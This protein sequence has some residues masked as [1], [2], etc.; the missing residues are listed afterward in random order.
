MSPSSE[1]SQLPERMSDTIRQNVSAYIRKTFLFSDDA[2]L[3][4][5]QSLLASG[6]IDS[7]GVLELINYLESTYGIRFGDEELVADN[8][9]SVARVS[10]FL[11]TKL[12]QANEASPEVP[13]R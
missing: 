8:F 3:D 5:D 10:A 9:D 11:A 13:G 4:P 12:S 2:N 1:E 7:T 6:V